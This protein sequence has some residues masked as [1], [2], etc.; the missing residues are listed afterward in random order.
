VPREHTW[1]ELQAIFRH[2]FKRDFTNHVN[3]QRTYILNGEAGLTLCS[4][5]DGGEPKFPFPYS[6]EVWTGIEYQVAA[7]LIYEGQLAEGL[8]I[9]KAVQ[10]RHDGV[11]RNPWNEVECG[12]HYARSMSSWAVLLA[13]SGVRCDVPRG[14]LS[15]DPVME[16]STDENVFTSFWSCGRGWGTYTQRRDT[17]GGAW[18]PS[19]EVLGGDMTGM[20]VKACGQEWTL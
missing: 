5:P 12:H 1:S 11:R 10:E 3:T 19:V 14:E 18:Q 13:L 8:E 15:F 2:N 9:I 16:A 17:P 4:W 7:H 6:D 20:R